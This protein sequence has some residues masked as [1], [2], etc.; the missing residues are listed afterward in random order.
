MTTQIHR[1]S[2][3][4]RIVTEHMPGLASA[5]IGI[6]VNA[7]ARHERVQQNGIAHFLEHMAFKGTERRSALQIAEAIE[8][9]GGYINAYTSREVTAYYARVLGN[10]V[11]LALDVMSD[12]LLNP[13]FDES[14]IEVERGVI[15]QEIGQ[16]LDTP[17]D[18]I[19]DW[20]QEK[21][22]PGQPLGRPIL[23]PSE[24]VSRFARDDLQSFVGEHYGPDQMIL[25]AAG[26]VDHDSLVEA[27][28]KLFG[29]LAPRP[30]AAAELGRFDGG[31]MRQVKALEQAHFALAFESPGYRDDAI[32]T[33][34]IY[35]G[36]LGGG[37]SSRLFQEIRENRGLCY[38]IFAQTGAYADTGM[39]TIYAGTSGEQLA[40]LATL[41]IDEMKRCAADLSPAEVA[42][43][44]AQMKAGLLM[45]LES[46]SNR[47]E[48]L[49]RLVQIWDRVPPLEETVA[50]IDAVTTGDVRE[51]AAHMAEQAPAAMALY[52][53]V[54]TAPTLERLQ[55]RRAA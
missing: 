47:A 35:S 44:R 51:F 52:G 22:F 46:P 30:R 5:S 3:G 38:S 40:D 11:A 32:Y 54:D 7:G 34:Q 1:L 37:M 49:A 9:V 26:M 13:V 33:A 41:T 42:R 43:A 12:I 23:G 19:F 20:L 24:R 21:A 14:E 45:G 25:S 8:D 4:F 48:R 31:E 16:S 39:T 50:R 18:V 36:A 29:H 28:E 55:E 53:P 10:D 2:N 6:W 27:A 15:L 17:D